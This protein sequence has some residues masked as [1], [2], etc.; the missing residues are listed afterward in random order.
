M[1]R[2]PLKPLIL[3][4]VDGVLN[5]SRAT[6]P[7]YRRHWVFPSGLLI[8]LLLNPKHGPMLL[9][10]AEETGCR[11]G[12]GHLLAGS[13]Q[14]VGRPPGRAARPA[15]R[16]DPEPP[17]A[18]PPYPVACGV[19]GAPCGVVA[20]AGAVRLV[21]GR[22]VRRRP[23]RQRAHLAPHLMVRVPSATGLTERHVDEA[24]T[25]LGDL[26]R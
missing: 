15:V 13:C 23:R 1:D 6:S 17:V 26:R 11:A 3:V 7:S 4:D 19:E 25:W 22:P 21:R 10:L 12:L 8:R 18:G 2:D 5:P 16:S 14:Y 24:R 20:R 9:A